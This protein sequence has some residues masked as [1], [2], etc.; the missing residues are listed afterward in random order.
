[1]EKIIS[2]VI[3]FAPVIFLMAMILIYSPKN[4]RALPP[5]HNLIASESTKQSNQI[6]FDNIKKTEDVIE[7]A[8]NGRVRG[9]R[10]RNTSKNT[11]IRRK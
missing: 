8:K 7:L 1:M 5:P 4:A 2:G 9:T 11:G 10:S 6:N 3:A